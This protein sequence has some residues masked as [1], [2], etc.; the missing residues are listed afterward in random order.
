MAEQM[1]LGRFLS[2]LP[3]GIAAQVRREKPKTMTEAARM[4]DTVTKDRAEIK[5]EYWNKPKDH[6]RNSP[7]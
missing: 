4:A 6:N 7:I 3:P 1:A 2:M 5:E